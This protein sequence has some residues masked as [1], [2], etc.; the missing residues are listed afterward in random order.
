M[1]NECF[2]IVSGI[3]KDEFDDESYIFEDPLF[4]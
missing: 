2:E 1:S 4:G 3:Y